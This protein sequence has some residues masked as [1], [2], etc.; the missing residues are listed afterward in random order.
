MDDFSLIF[1]IQKIAFIA[2]QN[3]YLPEKE[4]RLCKSSN[5]RKEEEFGKKALRRSRRLMRHRKVAACA[6]LGVAV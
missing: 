6:F 5:S 3:S 1:L 2:K 4:W